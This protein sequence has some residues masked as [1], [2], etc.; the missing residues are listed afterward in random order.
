MIKIKKNMSIFEKRVAFKP[1]EYPEVIK[2][3]DAI[4]QSRWDVEEFNFDSDKHEFKH[5]LND[6]ERE[7]IKRTL[8]SISQI[9][10]S[11]KSFWAKL[12]DH[13]PKPEFNSVGITFAENEV[14]HSEA[15]SK[16]L[17][18]LGFN[19]EFDQLL[20]NPIIGGRVEYLTK[21][22]KNS[23]DNSKQVYTLNLALFSMF[24][25]NVSLFSQFAIVKSF[26]QKKNLL[27]EIDTVI[28]ATMKEEIIHAQLGIYL[29]NLVKKEYPEW[30]DDEF[31]NKIYRAAKKA[32]EAESKIIDWIFEKGDID[33]ISVASVKEFIKVRFNDSVKSIGGEPVFEVDEAH[34]KELYWMVE[35]IYAYVRNDFFSTQGTNYTKFQKSITKYDLF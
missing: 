3:R 11:V 15:Y 25:E 8:L 10:V 26:T 1:Y 27:K 17:E 34:L 35:A 4:K 32:Y 19:S 20:Q 28:E 18:E 24:I 9:E 7:V 22:L 31:Y 14:V 16:L 5:E 23:G 13:F 29:I 2:Y 6:S 30:F 33:R 21:Y 12:G